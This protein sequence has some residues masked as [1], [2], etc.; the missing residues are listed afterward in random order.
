MNKKS[1]TA[2]QPMTENTRR[3]IIITAIIVVAVII[4][5]VALALILKP[6]QNTPSDNNSNS[7]GSSSLTI[8]NGDFY[9]TASDDTA[10]PKTAQNWSKYGYK[11]KTDSSHDFETISTNEKA[12]M[13]VVTTATEG[14]GDTWDTVNAD[15]QVEGISAINPGK[16]DSELEDDNVYMIATK[17]ATT[18][19]ILSDS[20]SVSSG[21]SVKITVWLNTAQLAPAPNT[22]ASASVWAMCTAARKDLTLWATATKNSPSTA[23]AFCLWTT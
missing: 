22:S 9:Y 16:H 21:K 23:K 6:G 8:R 7:G 20:F 5:S 18:A 11:A 2:V 4:L 17:E 10:Y 15:L 19:S 12:L 14:D 13:G 3:A 1:K